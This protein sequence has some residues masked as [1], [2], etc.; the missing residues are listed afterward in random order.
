MSLHGNKADT[1]IRILF[2]YLEKGNKIMQSE[3]SD[4]Q[5]PLMDRDF[6]PRLPP[7]H[8]VTAGEVE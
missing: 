4:S 2:A 7:T 1:H 8:L 5:L 3:S 6:H